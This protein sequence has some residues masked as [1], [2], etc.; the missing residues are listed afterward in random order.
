MHKL[1]FRKSFLF[2]GNSRSSIVSF[3]RS[4][5]MLQTCWQSFRLENLTITLSFV[6]PTRWHASIRSGEISQPSLPKIFKTFSSRRSP[7][8]WRGIPA[9]SRHSL[10]EYWAFAQHC[11]SK[12]VNLVNNKLLTFFCYGQ[13][14]MQ[15]RNWSIKSTYLLQN[16][17]IFIF[18]FALQ[19]QNNW[20]KILFA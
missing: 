18:Q 20:Y 17:V 10:L 15:L 6:L 3:F 8:T 2:P 11:L 19:G 4:L 7:D 13:L 9:I 14:C 12:L 5:L 1:P 16:C